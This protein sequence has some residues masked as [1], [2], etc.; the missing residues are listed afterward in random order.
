MTAFLKSVF[1]FDKKTL[2]KGAQV[3][4]HFIQTGVV[5]FKPSILKFF[6]GIVKLIIVR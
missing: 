1:T 2:K 4:V 6:A 5:S 3:G